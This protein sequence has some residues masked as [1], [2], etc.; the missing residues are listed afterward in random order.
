MEDFI[1][2]PGAVRF[3]DGNGGWQCANPHDLLYSTVTMSAREY[4]DELRGEWVPIFSDS[5]G[6][7]C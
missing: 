3:K 2:R 4:W 7:E 5:E 1:P 6:G